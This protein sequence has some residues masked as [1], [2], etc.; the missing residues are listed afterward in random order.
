MKGDAI[1]FHQL[2][3]NNGNSTNVC[4]TAPFVH[5]LNLLNPT[6]GKLLDYRQCP[7]DKNETSWVSICGL[8]LY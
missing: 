4:G 3:L 1:G 6:R 8:H 5:A 2:I 7:A